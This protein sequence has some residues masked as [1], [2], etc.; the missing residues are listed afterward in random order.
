MSEYSLPLL[1]SVY[2][3]VALKTIAYKSLTKIAGYTTHSST[4]IQRYIQESFSGAGVLG[5]NFEKCLGPR[6]SNYCKGGET[7]LL[8]NFKT[9]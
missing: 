4:G 7:P 6:P 3:S 2:K 1:Q 5:R 9:Y 8:K